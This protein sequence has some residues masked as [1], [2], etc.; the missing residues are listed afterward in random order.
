MT[1]SELQVVDGD[2]TERGPIH[3]GFT[4]HVP[5]A[6][7]ELLPSELEVGFQPTSSHNDVIDWYQSEAMT[8]WAC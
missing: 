7:S 6:S 2:N 4:A 8:G 5:P 3:C 1:D